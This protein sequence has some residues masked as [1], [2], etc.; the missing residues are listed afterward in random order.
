[1]E[2]PHEMEVRSKWHAGLFNPSLL[3]AMG[4]EWGDCIPWGG[5][6]S[7]G[8][9]LIR[10]WGYYEY[11]WSLRFRLCLDILVEDRVVLIGESVMYPFACTLPLSFTPFSA[12][13]IKRR[14]M[15]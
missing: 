15:Q 1:M 3:E 7:E 9:V 2:H 10:T 14:C 13:V 8:G 4:S 6:G 5:G 12:P 11:D